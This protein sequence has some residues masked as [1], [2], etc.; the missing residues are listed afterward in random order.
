MKFVS[1]PL[2]TIL[3]VGLASLGVAAP[4]NLSEEVTITARETCPLPDVTP[5]RVIIQNDPEE[6]LVDNNRELKDLGTEIV[7]K[8]FFKSKDSLFNFMK[9]TYETIDNA[10]NDYKKKHDLDDRSM[11]F[12]FKGGN[13]MRIIANGVFAM[14]PPEARDLL[15]ATYGDIF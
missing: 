7:V 1:L 9:L 8:E 3:L 5:D 6:P 11:F 10:L 15:Q 12:L 4:S 2:V 14:L 13:V